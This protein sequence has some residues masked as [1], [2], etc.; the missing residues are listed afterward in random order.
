LI[1]C[2]EK[3]NSTEFDNAIFSSYKKYGSIILSID[4]FDVSQLVELKIT[5]FEPEK[6]LQRKI[7]EYLLQINDFNR[8]F[9]S[10]IC[11]IVREYTLKGEIQGAINKLLDYS[12][13]KNDNLTQNIILLL[14]RNK[15]NDNNY[16]IKGMISYDD[17]KLEFNKLINAIELILN[18]ID[19]TNH[20]AR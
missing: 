15:L 6:Y 5:K 2:R 12:K 7:S 17:Y 20:V 8:N 16:Y 14:S 10:N 19:A 9:S 11:D 18:E 13:N 4:D 3:N 1:L